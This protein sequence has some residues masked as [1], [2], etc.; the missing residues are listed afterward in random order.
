MAHASHFQ[1]VGEDVIERALWW[2]DVIQYE[3]ACGVLNGGNSPYEHPSLEKDGK[4]GVTEMWA[5]AVGHIMEY[6]NYG[7]TL[8]RDPFTEDYWF[9]PEIVWELYKNGLELNNI[10]KSMEEDV[11]TLQLFK[12][13]LL[14]GNPQYVSIINSIFVF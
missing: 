5:H 13:R 10:S 11:T 4:V 9:K 7:R 14:E 8:G 1:Q 12:E 3:V 6:E 2:G